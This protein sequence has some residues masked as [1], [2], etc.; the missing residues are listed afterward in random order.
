MNMVAEPFAQGAV[1]Q[2]RRRVVAHGPEARSPVHLGLDRR[3][4]GRRLFRPAAGRFDFDD[5]IVAD[6][7]H[8]GDRRLA[9]LPRDPPRVGHLTAAFG[10]ER[11]FVKLE[12]RTAVAAVERADPGLGTQ[13]VVADERPRWETISRVRS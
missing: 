6:P 7:D 2:V 8:V 1:K 5:L 4:H 13:V 9:T 3:A 12:K 11:A 10:V